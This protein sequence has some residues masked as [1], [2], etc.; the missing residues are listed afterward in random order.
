MILF[1]EEGN[2]KEGAL[3]LVDKPLKWTSFDV[4]NKIRWCLKRE[5]GKLKV[6]HAGTLDPLATGLVIVCTGKWTK[7]IESHMSKIKEYVAELHLGA[8]TPSY[9][10]ETEVD[11]EYPYQHITLEL[12]NEVITKFI[13]EIDQAPPVFSAIRVNGVRAYEKARKGDELE[14]QLRKVFVKEIEVLKFEPPLV[15]LRIVCGK[16]T[17]IRSLA[18]DIG[19]ACESGAYLSALRRTFIG[20]HHIDRAY[21]MDDLVALLQEHKYIEKA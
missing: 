14:M 20:D 8:T 9:D 16:G 1:K 18:N 19:K 21:G 2:F 17:Y 10:L 4:V 11:H 7:E 5:Y 13:G 12:L 3:I 6:G 15:E